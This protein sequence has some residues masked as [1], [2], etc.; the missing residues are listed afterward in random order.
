MDRSLLKK[1]EAEPLPRVILVHGPETAWHD[2]VYATLQERNSKD[3]LAQWNWSVFHGEKDFVL[4][5][6]L[7]DLGTVSWG[8]SPKIVILKEAQLIP[9]AI[10]EKLASWLEQNETANSLAIFLDKVDNRWKYLKI[11]RQFALEIQCDPLQGEALMRY[12]QDYCTEQKKKM[13][14]KTAE[15]FLDRVGNNLQVVHNEL[16]K[17]ISFTKGREEVT[18]GDVRAITSL[19]PGQP[20]NNTIFQM[21]DFI[22]QKN[23]EKA[24]ELL[25]LLLSSGEPALRIL[26]LIERQY[27]LVLAAKTSTTSLDVTAKQMGENSSYALKKIQPLA[28]RFELAEIFAGFSA[29]V[30]ADRELKLGAPG[31]QVLTDLIIKLT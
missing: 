18:A 17:L 4:E 23:R 8:G 30:Q 19:L 24:L 21:T 12:V 26:P 13:T 16:E 28:K 1:I 14:R 10:M 27:R 15:V 6:L 31:D 3:S 25:S 9:A 7:T 5:A 29:V 20:A 22:V 2:L 11:M